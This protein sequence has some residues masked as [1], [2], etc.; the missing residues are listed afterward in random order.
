MLPPVLSS[1]VADSCTPNVTIE[2]LVTSL[3]EVSHKT[4]VLSSQHVWRPGVQG[5][6]G[7][8]AEAGAAR[9]QCEG[10]G[11]KRGTGAGHPAQLCG[12]HRRRCGQS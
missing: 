12:H 6:Q 1:R 9:L 4:P 2:V 11:Q 8:G 7:A 5:G 10:A 3:R